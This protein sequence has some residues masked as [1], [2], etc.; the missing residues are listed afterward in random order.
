MAENSN[1]EEKEE[2]AYYAEMVDGWVFSD[3]TFGH[4]PLDQRTPAHTPCPSNPRNVYQLERALQGLSSLQLAHDAPVTPSAMDT[5]LE[6]LWQSQPY[7]V[8]AACRVLPPNGPD[9]WGLDVNK[10]NLVLGEL[11]LGPENDGRN[12]EFFTKLAFYDMDEERDARPDK[13]SKGKGRAGL[14]LDDDEPLRYHVVWPILVEDEYGHDWV[15]LIWTQ[16]M[17]RDTD[18]L[19]QETRYAQIQEFYIV[20]PRLDG[21]IYASNFEQS[22][23]RRDRILM[24]FESLLANLDATCVVTFAPGCLVENENGTRLDSYWYAPDMPSH[25]HTSGERCYAV[26][27]QW[28]WR[29]THAIFPHA[30]DKAATQAR[31]AVLRHVNP[32]FE[33]MAMLGICAWVAMGSLSFWA[34]VS[35]ESL[36]EDHRI[37]LL[38]NGKPFS[39]IAD[40]LQGPAEEP[41]MGQ[42]MGQLDRERG[43]AREVQAAA[44]AQRA[45]GL[46]QARYAA[47]RDVIARRRRAVGVDEPTDVETAAVQVAALD[48]AYNASKAKAE[49]SASG[50]TNKPAQ[51]PYP[52]QHQRL[53]AAT[54]WKQTQSEVPFESRRQLAD[55]N[56]PPERKAGDDT[57]LGAHGSEGDR[58]EQS[59]GTSTPPGSESSE[60]SSGTCFDSEISD[61]ESL[62]PPPKFRIYPQTMTPRVEMGPDGRF[63]PLSDSD[64]PGDSSTKAWP[65]A[66]MG[67]APAQDKAAR[68]NKRPATE[69]RLDL[70]GNVARQD[71]RQRSQLLS[72]ESS[73]SDEKPLELAHPFSKASPSS[74][75]LRSPAKRG[76]CLLSSS[77]TRAR[78]RRHIPPPKVPGD[79]LG[80]PTVG[81]PRT[82]TRARQQMPTVPGA[83]DP[84]AVAASGPAT[85]PAGRQ[86]TAAADDTS[87]TSPQQQHAKPAPA[88]KATGPGRGGLDYDYMNRVFGAL[89][90]GF[91]LS[92]ALSNKDKHQGK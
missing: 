44:E 15:T 83:H 32:Y 77:P 86:K 50:A 53:A 10:A 88:P 33:R 64:D 34:R 80:A 65:L 8:R 28:M 85:I 17:R 73:S 40:E 78:T 71:K 24:R 38:V 58:L 41:Q 37:P 20:D 13:R 16:T 66:T 51:T 5:V 69:A 55:A 22:R 3:N 54:D 48:A 87:A 35:I 61:G 42:P 49:T 19:K 63:Y 90:G 29:L 52:Q 27:K 56:A 46:A 62:G 18:R 4:Q 89:A 57:V 23:D 2:Y 82:G 9:L 76:I 30:D 14:D 91:P 45:R 47:D 72:G 21:R 43:Q 68:S 60:G 6:V 67:Q 7:A 26:V 36:P 75:S 81:K 70:G 79:A 1:K 59:Q 25:E 92:G 74:G 11:A 12:V 84:S 31:S 39:L